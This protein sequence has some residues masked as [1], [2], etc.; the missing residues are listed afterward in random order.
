MHFDQLLRVRGHTHEEQYPFCAPIDS[1]GL[2]LLDDDRIF[3][4]DFEH[5]KRT[6]TPI[7]HPLFTPG[8]R[9]DRP[10]R[11]PAG[12]LVEFSISHLLLPQ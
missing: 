9:R 7:L 1:N 12:G 2:S 3:L 10:S 11:Q 5:L 8:P 4:D 6:Y